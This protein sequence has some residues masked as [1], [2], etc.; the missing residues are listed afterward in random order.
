MSSFKRQFYSQEAKLEFTFLTFKVRVTNIPNNEKVV[1][2]EELLS[3]KVKMAIFYPEDKD[4]IEIDF[5]NKEAVVDLFRALEIKPEM[6]D[7]ITE[8]AM[9]IVYS[10]CNPPS[11]WVFNIVGITYDKIMKLVNIVKKAGYIETSSSIYMKTHHLGL[12]EDLTKPIFQRMN[13]CINETIS[14]N[15]VLGMSNF[16]K[17]I[18]NNNK[19]VIKDHKPRITNELAMEIALEVCDDTQM[20]KIDY[21]LPPESITY[22]IYGMTQER[23]EKLCALIGHSGY[24]VSPNHIIF[25][26]NRPSEESPSKSPKLHRISC[27]TIRDVYF[28]D[29]E[30]ISKMLVM[31]YPQVPIEE[32][33]V[34][35]GQL[36]STD[37]LM[38]KM[39]MKHK[40]GIK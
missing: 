18:I 13:C 34:L 21:N 7:K 23:L 36:D 12:H 6:Y 33:R 16:I 17:C 40:Y 38:I 27:H 19:D 10:V 11:S 14:V 15:D 2:L 4:V 35:V 8:N 39:F 25:G 1:G 24:M 32:A 20:I 37:T 30:E 28:C 22:L 29:N 9:T 5:S 31:M 26:L 3:D